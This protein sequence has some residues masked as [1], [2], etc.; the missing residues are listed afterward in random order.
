MVFVLRFWF[1]FLCFRCVYN[2][3]ETHI[4]QVNQGSYMYQT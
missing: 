3:A 1:G 4:K 2:A